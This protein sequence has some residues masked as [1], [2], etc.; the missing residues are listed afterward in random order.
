MRRGGALPERSR[1][2]GIPWTTLA[3]AAIV[4]V[5]GCLGPTGPGADGGGD[6][7]SGDGTGDGTG[8][9]LGLNWTWTTAAEPA[10]ARGEAGCAVLDGTTLLVAGGFAEGPTPTVTTTAEVYDLGQ[11]AW[12]AA[13]DLPLPLHHLQVVAADGRFLVL[14]GYVGPSFTPTDAAFSWAP[15]E[16]AWTMLASLPAARGAGGAAVVPGGD[17]D[18]ARV[19]LAGGVGA[20]MQLL[21][22]VDAYD[23]ASD[24]WSAL[25]DLPTPRD[26]LAVDAVAAPTADD[27]TETGAREDGEGNDTSA[28]NGTR[29]L[30][31]AA[32]GRMQSFA[33]NT[34]LVEVYDPA[35]ERWMPAAP[36]P[37]ARGGTGGAGT[38]HGFVSAGGEES[39]GT[40][41]E[42]EGYDAGNGTWHALPDLPTPR[43]GLCVAWMDDGLHVVTGGLEPGFAVSRVHEVLVAG[44]V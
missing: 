18:T 28:A 6:G 13:P 5:A 7:G 12:S 44:P 2:H 40:F 16:D 17:G 11:D 37:T 14:G 29:T 25:P 21:A 33:T 34:D 41:A 8:P 32:Q 15:G 30:V 9:G 36:A 10:V 23:V 26:H 4:L 39:G 27:G 38:P 22:R 1:P 31:V 43:H 35:E 3:A 24:T 19:V 42:V 20:D